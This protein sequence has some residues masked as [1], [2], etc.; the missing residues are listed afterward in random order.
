MLKN[1]RHGHC[2]IIIHKRYKSGFEEFFGVL[3]GALGGAVAQHAGELAH[4]G[5]TLRVD[6]LDRDHGAFAGL[7]FLHQE[8]AV[9]QARD[10]RQVRHAEDLVGAGDAC[11]LLAHDAAD[12]A[13]DVG[14]QQAATGAK[15]KS[16][17]G[18]EPFPAK[19]GVVITNDLVNALRD[20]EGV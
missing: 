6:G 12:L 1:G 14:S 18:F 10:L 9:A 13:A 19:A 2:F 7:V 11:H 3:Q 16:A 17:A 5:F 8:V 15:R 4:P 20:A